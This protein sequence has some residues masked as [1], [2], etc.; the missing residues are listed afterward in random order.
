MPE[1]SPCRAF[2]RAEG[3]G[4]VLRSRIGFNGLIARGAAL[5][6]KLATQI[7]AVGLRDSEFEHIVLLLRESTRNGI[8][9]RCVGE[10]VYRE[11]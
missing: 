9:R 7:R 3:L 4:I 5:Q 6:T 8:A 10:N 2:R 11:E 1:R